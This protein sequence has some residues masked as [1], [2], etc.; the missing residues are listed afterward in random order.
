MSSIS[1]A[2]AL[3]SRTTFA[4]RSWFYD[5]IEMP[6]VFSDSSCNEAASRLL[7]RYSKLTKKWTSEKNSEWTCRL[8]MASKLIM[9]AT[10]HV[11]SM[12]Y[13]KERNLRVVLPYLRYYSVL[14]LLRAIYLTLPEFDW[15]D[16]SI[17]LVKH[18]PTI[19]AV[20]NQ[21]REFDKNVADWA[22]S[23]IYKLKAERELVS[24]R[25]P[26]SG[27]VQVSG[28]NRFLSL[29]TLLAE[30][31]QFNSELFELSLINHG[32][33][34]EFP[35]IPG[36]L[37]KISSVQIDDHYFVDCEDAYRLGYLARKHPR[38]TNLMHLMTE[39]HVEDFF[40]VWAS[41]EDSDEVFD[42]DTLNNIIFDIP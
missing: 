21:L 17:I 38:P 42:P 18:K 23:D 14:S 11:N 27:D 20:I 28:K 24:Y 30:L 2:K 35:L 39:G 1:T 40:G 7:M 16:G 15:K 25:S 41:Q 12:Y 22:E 31:A 19:K 3:A 10:L 37:E 36:Y 33:S 9:S 32:N 4:G 13:A 5:F 8:F 6:S 29:S 26:S 34:S